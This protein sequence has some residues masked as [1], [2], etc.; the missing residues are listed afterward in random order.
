MATYIDQNAAAIAAIDLLIGPNG[1]GAINGTVHRQNE[2]QQ[3]D[4]AYLNLLPYDN[5]ASKFV[6]TTALDT[7][8]GTN[9]LAAYAD[10]I[11]LTPNGSPLG[12]QNRV[13]LF[14]LP[15]VYDLGA[16]ALNLNTE[17]VDMIGL[18][19]N[20]SQ[21]IIKSVVPGLATGVINKTVD[22]VQIRNVSLLNNAAGVCYYSSVDDANT[23]L[24]NIQ[25]LNNGSANSY[26]TAP[27]A[28]FAGRYTNCSTS[29][30][31]AGGLFGD[32]GIASGYFENCTTTLAG[33]GSSGTA[34]GTF[35]NCAAGSGFGST[36]CSG[37]FTNCT[38]TA[39][40]FGGAG[41][42]TGAT[43]TNCTANSG[44]GYT[45]ID[46]AST[47][48]DCT[49]E[50]F[51][52]G[53]SPLGATLSG[54][55]IRCRVTLG[56]GFAPYRPSTLSGRFEDCSASGSSFGGN[57]GAGITTLSGYFL[58]C[59][60][61][62][63]NSFGNDLAVLSGEFI[64]CISGNLSFGGLGSTISGA[65][66]NC[67]GGNNC[68]AYGT[69]GDNS[70]KI[71]SAA[72]FRF[73]E[74][75]STSFAGVCEAEAGSTFVSCVAGDNSFAGGFAGANAGTATGT[76]SLCRG[77]ANAFGGG[78]V[79]DGTFTDCIGGV[80]S[81]A[82]SGLPSGTFLRCEG[83]DRSFG[84]G[85]AATYTITGRFVDCIGGD[86]SFG[87]I[88]T[89]VGAVFLNC[90]GGAD[91]FCGFGTVGSG[92]LY[93][94]CDG[95]L[96]SFNQQPGTTNYSNYIGCTGGDYSFGGQSGPFG[97]RY[98]YG[99]YTRCIGGDFAFFGANVTTAVSSPNIINVEASF[100]ECVGGDYAFGGVSSTGANTISVTFKPMNITRCKG[101]DYSFCGKDTSVGLANNELSGLVRDSEGGVGSFCGGGGNLSGQLFECRLVTGGGTSLG[102]TSW[103][104][105]LSG[106]MHNCEWVVTGAGED[107][108]TIDTPTIA[109][110]APAFVYGCTIRAGAGGDAIAGS[111]TAS[112]A[113]CRLNT[114]IGG[115]VVNDIGTPYN[116]V[117]ADV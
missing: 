6:R 16:V 67:I 27:T 68:F 19:T 50:I 86:K 42:I 87:F 109:P 18:S 35:V 49:S 34:S 37:T 11:T 13:T 55:F 113:H 69:A 38:A 103:G 8:N 40:G 88:A 96:R 84:G 17:Y 45:S 47:L 90:R 73:C 80:G 26:P 92:T 44:F 58:R 25:F 95:G 2:N 30:P 107:G 102:A 99:E 31:F 61:D 85:T 10:A 98:A 59:T 51:A 110:F 43:L 23:L 48:T 62:G 3:T 9:L 53:A 57:L 117:D 82:G 94:G 74:A 79:A 1:T 114:A 21:V 5:T 100:T 108:V 71:E 111:G 83:G 66:R 39:E 65:F 101:G 28:T 22:N 20:E 36:I 97:S 112:I 78:G 77:G 54:T 89:A 63:T 15:G 91:S 46:A 24:D 116:V 106:S 105:T 60:S 56:S 4:D 29:G 76:Y 115:T 64:D 72:S 14:L 33:F 41:V 12:A 32:G 93:D 7:D 81:F 104:G 75:G 52:F 70:A